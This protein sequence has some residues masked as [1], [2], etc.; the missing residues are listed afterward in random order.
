MP[1][2]KLLAGLP[3]PVLFALYGALGGLLGALALGEAAWAALRPPP[4]KVIDPPPPLPQLALTVSPQVALYPGTENAIGVQ[5][6]RDGFDG[7]VVVTFSGAPG[8]SA[9]R[10]TVP[11][12]QTSARAVVSAERTAPAGPVKLE[13][14]ATSAPPDLRATATLEATVAP[15]PPVPPRL[16]VTASPAV[17]VLQGESSTFGV[18]VARDGF[19]GPV[20]VTFP[21]L[22]VGLTVEPVTVPSGAA[23]AQAVL[24]AARKCPPREWQVAVAAE[25][26]PGAQPLTARS[27]TAL[28]VLEVPEPQPRIALTASPEVHVYA[29]AKN[30]LGV[31]IARGDFDDPVTVRFTDLPDGVTVEPVTLPR[32]STEATLTVTAS[33]L[34]EKGATKATAVA[35]GK[36]ATGTARAEVP[37]LV[38]VGALPPDQVAKVDVVF[39]LDVTGSMGPFLQGVKDGIKDFANGLDDLNL[40]ARLGLLAFGDR[41]NGEEPDVLKFGKDK[42]PFTNDPAAFRDALASI[43]VKGGG[44]A[45]ESSLDGLAEAAAFKFRA[46]TTRVL[47]LITDAPPKVPDKLTRNVAGAVAALGKYKIDQVHVVS[48]EADLKAHYQPLV[49][50]FRGKHF[51]L[52]RVTRGG[53]KF[54][55]ILPELGKAIEAQVESKPAPKA[56]VAA[57][58]AVPVVAKAAD[59]PVAV[60]PDAPRPPALPSAAAAK[61]AT[62]PA[63]D[64]PPPVLPPAVKGVQSTEVYDAAKKGQLVLAVGAWTGAIAALVCLALV[65]GQT[66]YL[67]GGGPRA[68]GALAAL[69]GGL[70]VGLLG[71]AAGQGLFLVAESE[72]FRVLGWALLGALAGAGLSLFVPNLKIVYGLLGGAAGG[73]AGAL[74]FVGVSYVTGDVVAR[75]SGGLLL[76][77]SIGLML[78]LVEKAF[79]S[80][81]LE[82]RYGPRETIQVN[83]G[84]EPVQIGGDAKA[85]TVWARGAAP[86]ALRFFVRDGRV[87]CEDAVTRTETVVGDGTERRAG[88]VAVVVRTG[89]GAPDA[90]KPAPEPPARTEDEDLLPMDVVGASAPASPPPPVLPAA[91]AKP[92]IARG[93]TGGCPGCGRAIPGEP[94]TRYCLLCDETF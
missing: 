38:R 41:V 67:Q 18:Q 30:T 80:A 21:D 56:E 23:R 1:A 32:G 53:E 89:R 87:V 68:A 88:S 60:A 40:D 74:A 31:K 44:D 28:K 33:K 36:H 20:T 17:Q 42:S 16:A 10:V 72:S 12:G 37:V 9:Q 7:P 13:A 15:L 69:V 5:I 90:P 8:V 62:T 3:K 73:A 91:G 59:A 84:T 49:E 70:L 86:I 34:A 11:A 47:L 43:K 25:A 48:R 29:R 22:P 78:A 55:K 82:V 50:K 39:V 6:A 19:D 52:D 66:H 77:A 81:W 63:R 54:A 83:L 85:C 27:G 14:T 76:G 51:D 75:L 71:G 46:K 58:A 65:V 26:L 93:A 57:G 64:A 79:R 2:P 94:G 24:R 92:N 61:L 45:P 4:P 35:E